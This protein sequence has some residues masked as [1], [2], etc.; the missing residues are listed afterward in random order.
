M[1]DEPK[2][3]KEEF[4]QVIVRSWYNSSKDDNVFM[5]TIED[6]LGVYTG[7][8][9]E[10]VRGLEDR[11]EKRYQKEG[12]IST[13][14]QLHHLKEVLKE[15]DKENPSLGTYL[16]L[17]AIL[18]QNSFKV[19]TSRLKKLAKNEEGRTIIKTIADLLLDYA[20]HGRF[21]YDMKYGLWGMGTPITRVYYRCA[22]NAYSVL[23]VSEKE[24]ESMV[25]MK[26]V[27]RDN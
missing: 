16:Q 18:D 5:G 10:E 11:F 24:V 23:G 13:E 12:Y 22:I 17:A 3:S 26:K 6:L 2:L 21:C 19:I 7:V 14:R 8:S 25:D 27:M 15:L 4:I 9:S 20:Q 1:T